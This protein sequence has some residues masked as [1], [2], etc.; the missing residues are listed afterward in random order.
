MPGA[1]RW[2]ASA[3]QPRHSA[4][5]VC[6]RGGA[7]TTHHDV[8]DEPARRHPGAVV[9]R[10]VLFT[11]DDRVITSAGITSGIDLALH[12]VAGLSLIHISH[13]S[14]LD[15]TVRARGRIRGPA[16]LRRLRVRA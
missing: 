5:P 12:L 1:A 4:R 11:A 2:P 15:D 7:G 9:V 10:D 16:L 8:Q 14:H 6:S 13:R 3:P